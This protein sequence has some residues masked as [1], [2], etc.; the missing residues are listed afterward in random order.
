MELRLRLKLCWSYS[1]LWP[2]RAGRPLRGCL[3][4]SWVC[5]S[6]WVTLN[7]VAASHWPQR[8]Q[9]TAV[10]APAL[11]K[12]CLVL[13]KRSYHLASLGYIHST[14]N[15]GHR[16]KKKSS[17]QKDF[18]HLEEKVQLL[19]LEYSP[20]YLPRGWF[21]LSLDME[22]ITRVCLGTGTLKA[23]AVQLWWIVYGE[24]VLV[25]HHATV[26]SHSHTP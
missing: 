19:Q 20:F 23:W 18:G 8:C 1:C 25:P 7:P 13:K 4:C 10:S 16:E 17:F 14:C 22:N 6:C 3:I 5:L 11:W 12:E 24:W 21:Q 26:Q 2:G 15:A 9:V